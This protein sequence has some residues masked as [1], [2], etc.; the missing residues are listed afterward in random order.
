MGG[1]CEGLMTMKWVFVGKRGHM[2]GVADGGGR[3]N[4]GS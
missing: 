1:K 3:G 2:E 4:E